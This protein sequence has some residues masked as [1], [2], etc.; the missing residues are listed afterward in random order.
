MAKGGR[1]VRQKDREVCV[2]QRTE[3]VLEVIQKRGKAGK[4]LERL[5]RQ[6]FNAEMYKKAYSE[7]YANKGAITPGS[8]KETLEGMSEG[9]I[10]N[11]VQR[12]RTETYRWQPV[13][14]TYIPK[15]N[16]ASRPLGIS[17]GD[18]KL[19]QATMKN[20]LEAYYEPTFS[21]RSHRFRPERGC[22]TAL[23]QIGQTHRDVSWFIEGDIMGCFDNI[24]HD[25]LLEIM[26]EKIKD[27]RFLRLV[28]HLAKAGY[29]EEWK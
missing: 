15:G 3:T 8:S 28:K 10:A 27:Q 2:R 9:R 21:T 5:Y 18:D 13:R 16:G 17:S 22:H 24:D 6:L 29:V 23:Q 11:I 14:R 20:L 1:Y 25:I 12:I 26:G 19:L 7:I 4:P